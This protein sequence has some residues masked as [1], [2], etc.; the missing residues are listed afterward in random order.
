M[1][2]AQA[3]SVFSGLVALQVTLLSRITQLTLDWRILLSQPFQL[4]F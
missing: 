3:L 1:P 2:D 4:S